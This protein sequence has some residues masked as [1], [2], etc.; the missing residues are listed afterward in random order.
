[1]D[2]RKGWSHGPANGLTGIVRI[3][4][5]KEGMEMVSASIGIPIVIVVVVLVI[6]VAFLLLRRR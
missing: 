6:I 4:S 2:S 3:E 1:M 5:R